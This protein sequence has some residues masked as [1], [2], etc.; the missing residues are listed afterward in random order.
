MGIPERRRFETELADLEAI[1]PDRPER[2]PAAETLA[3]P[4]RW[5]CRLTVPSV[6]PTDPSYGMGTG[7]LIGPRHVLTAAHV[8]V[9]E[10]DPAKTVG[11]RLRVQPA[12]NGSAARFKEV[13]I[14]GWQVHPHAY[15][16][17]GNRRF[18]Q[19]QH[20]YGLVTLD[21]NVSDW[22]LGPCPLGYWGLPGA[23]GD[24][25]RVGMAAADVAGQEV[26]VTGY[27]YDKETATLWS[28]LGAITMDRRRGALLHTADT[29]R[30]QSG[31][32]VWLIRA[33]RCQLVG[34]HSGELGA[35]AIDAQG[36]QTLTHNAGALLS[37]AVVAQL[38][39]WMRTFRR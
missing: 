34:V 22:S 2:V 12:R 19:P 17:A 5:I 38:R 33:G 15:A 27:R 21:T 10:R 25:A 6:D 35:W 23:C 31:S 1:G 29:K 4:Y 39:Q 7:V 24:G 11:D 37:A 20:D 36:N 18:L 30:G 26:R 16:R 9:S 8:L 14:L 13:G 28:G 3:V 32:P